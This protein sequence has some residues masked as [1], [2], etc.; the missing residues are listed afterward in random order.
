MIDLITLCA[1]IGVA[2]E[3][4]PLE[5]RA[6]N[7][8]K[9]ALPTELSFLDNPKYLDD[10]KSTKAGAV[11]VSAL[12]K[13]HVP[14]DTIALVSDE[15]YLSMAK[16]SKFFAPPLLEDNLPKA[17][18]G[19][20]TFLAPNAYIANGAKIGKN[21][22]IMPNSFIGTKVQIGDDVIV[23]PNVSIYRDCIIGSRVI[24]HSGSVVGS[25]GFGYA[26]TKMG[27]HVKI[28]QNG[29]V[30][31]ED[32]VELGSNNSIDCAVF[33]STVIKK[34]TKIDNLVQVGHNCVVG[35][36]TILVS[37]CGIAGSTKLGRNVVMGGQS[38]TAGHLSIAPFTTFAAR[39]GV[40]KDIKEP[41]Q[42]FAGFPLMEHRLWMK[43]QAKIA[44]L[45][46]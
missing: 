25:D 38:A 16:A 11:L 32:D 6:I 41:H 28:Y 24:I 10:L 19:E 26:H 15:V 12:M 2:Y 29:N 36:H 45:I 21:C 34:G 35:E 37:Q 20:G 14:S 7:T 23:H 42:T 44:R 43:L 18:I 9:D 5:I 1:Q 27:E 13:E 31:I 30:I 46:K 17:I 22:I 3:G 39:S 8:L 33:G 4:K 40:T